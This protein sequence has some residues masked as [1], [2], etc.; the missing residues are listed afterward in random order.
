MSTVTYFW[1]ERK[2]KALQE[3]T[4]VLDLAEQRLDVRREAVKL[5]E[6][7]LQQAREAYVEEAS[8]VNDC[9]IALRALEVFDPNRMYDYATFVPN[10]TIP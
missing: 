7:K 6:V 10:Q 4:K 2:A 1:E 8:R 5:A 9:E 3:L